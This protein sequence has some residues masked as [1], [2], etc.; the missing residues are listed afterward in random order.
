MTC[1]TFSYNKETLHDTVV[2][3]CTIV[4]R[5]VRVLRDYLTYGV[6]TFSQKGDVF[7]QTFSCVK[8][9]PAAMVERVLRRTISFH[10]VGMDVSSIRFVYI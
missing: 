5:I 10:C 2:F 8:K 6:L 4:H 1:S 9:I 3:Q 7:L